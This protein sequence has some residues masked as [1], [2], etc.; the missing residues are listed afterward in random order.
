MNQVSLL[1]DKSQLALVSKKIL[2]GK[3]GQN[4]NVLVKIHFGEPGNQTALFPH[5]VAPIIESL[6]SLGL[7][8]TL[9]D[10]P[11]A[12]DSPRNTVTGYQQAVRD[13]GYDTLAPFIISDN[14][15][16]VK[17]KDLTVKV[18]RELVEAENLLVI[19]HVKGHPCS[20]F[21]GA[22]KNFGM[23]GVMAESK[24]DIHGECKPNFNLETC[25]G[26]GKCAQLCPA[27]AITIVN[28]KAQVNLAKC[29][30][31][32]I[33]Q[34]NC[35]TKSL[36]PKVAIFDDLL[37]QGASAC[38]NNLPQNTYYI[39]FVHNIT[40]LCDC[41]SDSGQIIAPDQGILFSD[42]PIAIDQAS[43]DL[44]GKD[45]FETNNHKDPN[46][47]IKYCQEYTK[48]TNEYQIYGY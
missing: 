9:I 11:V 5:D 35:P 48:F 37:A 1:T 4:Q 44:V 43:V 21:G 20:G 34:V 40:K 45:I 12:Y 27:G 26:C 16:E 23:G 3:F 31:C 10:T 47:H 7:S 38:I 28:N 42:N 33:C 15:V 41:E 24:K 13:R 46:L 6:K 25:T 36:T 14:F 18:C 8:P 22:I 29:W 17:T 39:N 2:A 30:G 32:S 19:S